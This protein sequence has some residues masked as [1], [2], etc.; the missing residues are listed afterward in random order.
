MPRVSR[1]LGV[2]QLPRQRALATGLEKAV[3]Q[4]EYLSPGI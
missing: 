2:L 1:V 4:P 3:V